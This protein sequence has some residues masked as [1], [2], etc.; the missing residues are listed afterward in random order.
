MP[1]IE[2]DYLPGD[3]AFYREYAGRSPTVREV[4][5]S[6]VRANEDGALYVILTIDDLGPAGE[7]TVYGED[8]YPTREAAEQQAKLQDIQF[9]EAQFYRGKD[10]MK[11]ALK[12]L[13]ELD[14]GRVD[15]LMLD[16]VK[17]A[18]TALEESA[19]NQ[20]ALSGGPINEG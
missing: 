4:R 13:S 7:Y 5:I 12:K 2:V 9:L 10:L 14:P 18:K 19:S 1:N 20:E 6:E 17:L 16:S 15:W 3:H 8:L 11:D